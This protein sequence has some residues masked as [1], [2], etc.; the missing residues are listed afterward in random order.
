MANA[1]RNNQFASAAGSKKSQ[2]I[3]K[4]KGANRGRSFPRKWLR[5]AKDTKDSPAPKAPC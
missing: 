2:E 1:L 3:A 5:R 4:G